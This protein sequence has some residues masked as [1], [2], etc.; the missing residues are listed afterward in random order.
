MNWKALEQ[1]FPMLYGKHSMIYSQG[2]EAERFYYLK[3]GSVRIFLASEYGNERTLM[4]VKEGELF[5]EA[6]FF[7]HMPRLSSASAIEKSQI[8]A[9]DRQKF[10]QLLQ[11][12]PDFAV[13]MM[14]HLAMR[15]RML[16]AQVDSMTFLQADCR[17]AQL[18]LQLADEHDDLATTHEA[19]ADLAGL[20]RITVSKTI[21]RF[22]KQGWIQNGYRKIHIQDKQTLQHFI[23]K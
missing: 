9:I 22:A 19:L 14:E 21:S 12:T 17:I 5:G 3:K 8:V 7:D 16:S 4:V 11:S 20:S 1:N 13:Q 23:Q 6:A 18:L 2:E 15:V 10:Q